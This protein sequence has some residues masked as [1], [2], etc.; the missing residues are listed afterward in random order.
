MVDPNFMNQGMFSPQN[1]PT[2]KELWKNE[3]SKYRVWIILFG[4]SI[5]GI[6]TLSLIGLILN[7]SNKDEVVKNLISWG[8]S[9]SSTLT[10]SKGVDQE[11]AIN[12]WANRFYRNDLIITPSIKVTV[13]FIGLVLYIST[14]IDCYRK[15]TFSAISKWSTFVIGVG[16]I[17]GVYQL[18]TIWNGTPIFSYAYGIYNFVGYIAPILVFIFVSIP[19]NKIR[20]Q[21]LISERITKL[22]NSPEFKNF[23]EQMKNNQNPMAGVSP[24][25]NPSFNQVPKTSSEENKANVNENSNLQKLR[26]MRIAELKVIAKKLSISGYNTMK[27]D[28]L[29]DSIL[30]VSGE[31]T[32][33]GD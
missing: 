19:I 12:N 32:S 23:Q 1:V 22:K 27:K 6:L 13:L 33:K 10:F 30:R 20:N 21:F 9:P 29:I 2:P 25:I 28:E 18:F 31:K 11:I 7:A 15:K 14:I 17:I 4:F 24:F 8:G 26:K 16:A 3:K 5:L